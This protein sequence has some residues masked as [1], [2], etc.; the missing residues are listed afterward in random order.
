[1]EGILTLL[2]LAVLAVPI[3]LIVLLATVSGL[4][5]R[6]ADLEHR[7]GT[8][9]A[10]RA[11]DVREAAADREAP[12][13]AR[14]VPV[15]VYPPRAPDIDT[16]TQPVAPIPVP[17]PTPTATATAASVTE[18]P[19]AWTTSG[20]IEL[21]DASPFVGAAPPAASAP[22]SRAPRAAAPPSGPDPV[23]RLMRWVHRWFTEGN[24]PVKVGMLVLFAGVAAL[25][26]Y[27]TDQGWMRFPIELRLAGV[28]LA[29][30]A[31]LV[32][33]WRQ[34]ERK[35][36]FA[37]SL[38]GGA[39]GILLL[40]VFA[41]AR[42]YPFLPIGAAF[43]LS[44][45]LVAA[46]GVLA[47]RQNAVALAVLGILA[48]F[49]APLWLSTGQGSH[50]AL[51]GYYAL[52][53]AAILGI[54]W[55]RPWRV[56]NLLGFVFT[57]VIGTFW[58]V[59]KYRPED[60]AT[61]EPFLL[62]FFAFYLLIP[63]LY[64]RRGPEDRRD[65][66]DGCLVFGMPLVVFA[67]Q[68]GLMEG[69]RMPLAMS[70]VGLAA[71]YT[72][73][74]W[75][76]QRRAQFAALVGPYA[77]LAVGFA[78][79]AVPLAL[80]A[81][82]TASVF[83][84]EGAALV[85]LGLRQEKRL[86]IGTGVALQL[87]AA[88]AY[89]F[90]SQA[91]QAPSV[92]IANPAFMGA[93]LIALAAFASA[94][95]LR[96]ADRMQPAAAFYLWGLAWWLGAGLQEI[97]R[98]VGWDVAPDWALGLFA[99]TGWVA[100]EV[101]RRRRAPVLMWSAVAALA[102]ALPLV[103]V[104]NW[105]HVWP[106]GG[107][108]PLAWLVYAAAGWRILRAVR[109]DDLRP[110][111]LAHACWLLAWAFMASLGIDYALG[112]SGLGDGWRIT[113]I[114]L[115]WLLI[116]AG[117]QWQPQR[118]SPLLAGGLDRSR[119]GLLMLFVGVLACGW[120]VTLMA[121]G[122]STPLPWFPM[123]NPLDLVQL[124]ALAIVAVWLASA[125]A[126]VMLRERRTQWLAGAG[127]VLLSV[128]T[129]RATHHWGAVAWDSTMFGTSLVQMS[130]TVV[131]SVLGVLGWVIGSR[132]GHRGLWRVGA[133]LMAVVL[134]KLVLVDRQHLGSGF[135]I[136]SFIAYGLLCTAVGYFA[137]APA[138]TPAGRDDAAANEPQEQTP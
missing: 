110:V 73:L 89:M 96:A 134:A 52:L 88:G 119:A 103:F 25:L 13:T 128:I 61:T 49:L 135:G 20:P 137:P 62:L 113:L 114:A 21:D 15:A 19:E 23:T 120:V 46:A 91:L 132:R 105:R 2:V 74:A 131:W 117:L 48:G 43:A 54:A 101:H 133:V 104:Q 41:A 17:T 14:E 47:V 38:Q 127:F 29:A 65:L 24:V 77:V 138:V 109:D 42:L 72:A 95:S 3:L 107:M 97:H 86:Q 70:A 45:V 121:P 40:V 30:L 34:R 7:L 92:P 87:L 84:L 123:L 59:L 80:S 50:V 16:A 66:V 12:A 8:L 78:T 99:L 83:A 93:L 55:V 44:V 76:L 67:L 115:P 36:A 57:F 63:I 130:L 98:F 68:A 94:W 71:I 27:A 112:G 4:K 31:G 1:M 102:V 106:L 9:H 69:A 64:A 118:V 11:A 81:H 124:A 125:D 108:G 60:F 33:G 26:K 56:L 122:S 58:G 10:A 22:A 82:A 129:L 116:A 75:A 32:F 37:L 39:I 111:G 85:W 51:F 126:L 18:I 100:A 28:A 79:L 136:A 90:G 35:R 6:V 5:A 53:N